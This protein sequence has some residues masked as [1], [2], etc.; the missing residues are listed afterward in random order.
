MLGRG[1]IIGKKGGMLLIEV[2]KEDEIL[3][4]YYLKSVG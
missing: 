2:D 3:G 1:T 4:N